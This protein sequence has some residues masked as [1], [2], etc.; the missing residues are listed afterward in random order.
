[1]NF[2]ERYSYTKRYFPHGIKVRNKSRRNYIYSPS[3]YNIESRD[4]VQKEIGFDKPI[5]THPQ[6]KDSV[7]WLRRTSQ[8]LFHI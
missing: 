6:T 2:F 7:T 1:M 5:G 4:K 3:I 8:E